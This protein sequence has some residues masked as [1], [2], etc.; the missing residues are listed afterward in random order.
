M[1]LLTD[2]TAP[3][4]PTDHLTAYRMGY[5][6]QVQGPKF[7]Y[8][9]HFHLVRVHVPHIYGAIYKTNKIVKFLRS[10]RIPS[11]VSKPRVFLFTRSLL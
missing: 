8:V 10:E 5:T 4:L 7:S 2:S 3:Q 9:T 6:P 1:A 11:Q